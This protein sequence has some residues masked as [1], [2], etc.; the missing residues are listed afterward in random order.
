MDPVIFEESLAWTINKYKSVSNDL[1][2]CNIEILGG[3]LLILP[4]TYIN[5]IY[6]IIKRVVSNSFENYSLGSQTNLIGSERKIENLYSISNGAIGTSTDNFSNAR[7]INGSADKYRELSNKGSLVVENLSGN[8]PGAVIVFDSNNI[9]DILNEYNLATS[10]GRRITIRQ[11]FQGANEVSTADHQSMSIAW[12]NLIKLWFMKGTISINPFDRIIKNML[13]V[14]DTIGC[15]FWNTCAGN[16]INME[17]NGDLYLCQEMADSEAYKLGNAK[18]QEW[19]QQ[20]FIKLS[21][22]RLHLSEDCNSCEFLEY[23]QGGCML[24]VHL[25]SDDIYAKP[26]SCVVWKSMFGAIKKLIPQ[27]E[28]TDIVKWLNKIQA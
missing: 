2:T 4:T 12:E 5:E 8:Y 13:G 24:E 3:E 6:S 22:R 7:S 25:E 17:P 23:C 1:T 14:T 11:V 16:S 10:L 18:S 26:R 20:N 19:S 9:L 15:P 21:K 28:R 27:Y